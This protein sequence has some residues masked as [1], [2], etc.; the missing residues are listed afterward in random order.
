EGWDDVVR[1]QSGRVEYWPGLGR[2]RF[3]ERVVMQNS[4]RLRR[5][6]GDTLLLADVDGDGCADLLHFSARGLA[7]YLNQNGTRF[8]DPV[9]VE[10]VPV[11]IAGTVRPVNMNGRGG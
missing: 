3:G 6:D 4:P 1:L 2:G 8:A 5:G 9:V 7:V 11:P 10:N